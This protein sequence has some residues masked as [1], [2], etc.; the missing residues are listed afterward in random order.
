MARL[1][2]YYNTGTMTTEQGAVINNP[3]GT[4]NRIT[5]WELW[6]EPDLNNETPCAPPSGV[7]CRPRST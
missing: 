4:S 1:V 3:A 5:Y 7:A 2:S 6:N